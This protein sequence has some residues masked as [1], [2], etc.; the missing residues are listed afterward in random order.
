[1][2]DW[3]FFDAE[4]ERVRPS[5]PAAAFKGKVLAVG[6]LAEAAA[7]DSAELCHWEYREVHPIGRPDLRRDFHTLREM[8]AGLAELGRRGTR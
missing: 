4:G 8:K 3:V 5:D 1:M 7:P 6:G 2:P